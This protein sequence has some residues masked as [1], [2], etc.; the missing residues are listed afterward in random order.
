MN[1]K[2]II[3]Q[4]LKKKPE[5]NKKQIL[6]DLETEKKKTGGLI[7]EETLLRLIA[8]RYG[9]LIPQKKIIRRLT[10]KQLVSGLNDVT[11]SGRIL[12]IFPPRAF[13]GKR[14]GKV[15]NLIVAEKETTL[16]VVLWNDNVNLIES[17]QLKAGQ[18]VRLFH[19]YTRKDR[20]GQLELHL[21]RKS[22][23]VIES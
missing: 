14:S 5:T 19:G 2:N 9:V 13:N 20:K 15:A 7:G 10:I 8:A 22:R 12:S 3:N 1:T 17:G 23:M 11:V 4:I 16:R 6:E 21:G 18:V